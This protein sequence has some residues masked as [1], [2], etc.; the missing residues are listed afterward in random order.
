MIRAV[1]KVLLVCLV[2]AAGCADSTSANDGALCFEEG[3]DFTMS[4]GQE[5]LQV[6]NVTVIR[7]ASYVAVGVCSLD[8]PLEGAALVELNTGRRYES[9]G[10]SLSFSDDLVDQLLLFPATS[11]GP[12][13]LA[14]KDSVVVDRLT[15]PPSPDGCTLDVVGD[16]AESVSCGGLSVV[17]IELP[18]RVGT[19]LEDGILY[20]DAYELIGDTRVPVDSWLVDLVVTAIGFDMR[21]ALDATRPADIAVA[22]HEGFAAG[23][24]HYPV[25]EEVEFTLVER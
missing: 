19:D 1:S 24:V 22:V 11:A 23:G 20:F 12:Y 14:V 7:D 13:E 16:D 18:T 25:G 3:L 5:R 2:A 4:D 9:F 8:S 15:V 21:V 10:G 17:D 6:G